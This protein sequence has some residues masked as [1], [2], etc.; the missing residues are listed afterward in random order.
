[1]DANKTIFILLTEHKDYIAQFYRII[2]ESAYTHAAIGINDEKFFSFGIKKGF[3]AEK[4]W[5]FT[6][7]K[8]NSSSCALYKLDV[9]EDSYNAIK[10]RIDEFWI[11]RKEYRFSFIGALFCMLRIPHHF[12]KQYF[13]SRFVAELLSESGAL[14]LKKPPSLYHPNDFSQ[15]SQLALCFQGKLEELANV[16]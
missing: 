1:M 8:K 14:Q 5:L 11:N 6:K 4:P 9:S 15:E 7:V 16:I 3:R 12:K 13:C 2:T 10:N